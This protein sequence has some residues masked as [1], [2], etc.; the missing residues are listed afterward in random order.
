MLPVEMFTVNL[1]LVSGEDGQHF[2]RDIPEVDIFGTMV[3]LSRPI[4]FDV[5]SKMPK[6]CMDIDEMVDYY[7]CPQKLIVSSAGFSS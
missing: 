6:K 2:F 4:E 1:S 3:S 5:R 7:R